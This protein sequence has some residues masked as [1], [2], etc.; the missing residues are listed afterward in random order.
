MFEK[1]MSRLGRTR[2]QKGINSFR[3]NREFIGFSQREFTARRFQSRTCHVMS[4]LRFL[5][6]WGG[7][8][9]YVPGTGTRYR[10]GT[11]MNVEPRIAECGNCTGTYATLYIYSQRS[12]DHFLHLTHITKSTLFVSVVQSRFVS[13]T[14]TTGFYQPLLMHALPGIS[15]T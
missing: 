3:W 1:E 12:Q 14:I 11:S 5:E 10:T 9:H 15:E 7:G 8:V 4:C 2:A 6:F 13:F